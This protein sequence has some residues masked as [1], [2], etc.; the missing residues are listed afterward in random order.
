MTKA[1]ENYNY[2][3]GIQ[4]YIV[5]PYIKEVTFSQ[6]DLG[7]FTHELRK[8]Y[9]DVDWSC[10]DEFELPIIWF[11]YVID[12]NGTPENVAMKHKLID[13]WKKDPQVESLVDIM[14][15]S[16][17]VKVE[18]PKNILGRVLKA[19]EQ[20]K[21]FVKENNVQDNELLV[22]SHSISLKYLTTTKFDESGE[23][24]EFKW[25]KNAEVGEYCL[26]E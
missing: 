18:G 15:Q 16:W 12:E 24:L 22:V 26:D 11:L 9:P 10:L 3:S 8:E 7:L 14:K 6:C 21:Q 25:F 23:P 2:K 13:A 20:L 17:P 1:L 19:K 4:K 5:N